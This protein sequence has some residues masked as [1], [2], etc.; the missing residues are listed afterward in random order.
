ME[1]GDGFTPFR[2]H[3]DLNVSAPSFWNIHK[4]LDRAG[5]ILDGWVSLAT[6]CSKEI[7]DQGGLADATLPRLQQREPV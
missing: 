2:L 6:V 1:A 4:L 3:L 5:A 7:F